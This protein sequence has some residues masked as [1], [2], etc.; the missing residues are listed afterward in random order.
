MPSE[1]HAMYETQ[2]KPRIL[3]LGIGGGVLLEEAE[4]I[5]GRGVAASSRSFLT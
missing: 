4:C 3:R 1:M 2:L 5:R